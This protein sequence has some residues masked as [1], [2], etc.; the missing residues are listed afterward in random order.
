M[1]EGN[2]FH[3]KPLKSLLNGRNVL[4]VSMAVPDKCAT[5]ELRFVINKPLHQFVDPTVET[6]TPDH[7]KH[8]YLK[9]I[10]DERTRCYEY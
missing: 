9:K 3:W 10:D 5:T 7:R 8:C 1:R 2:F 4:Q 6:H